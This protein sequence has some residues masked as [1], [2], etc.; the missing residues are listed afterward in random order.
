MDLFLCDLVKEVI[1]F[2][3]DIP[4]FGAGSTPE[5]AGGKF[6]TRVVVGT[7]VPFPIDEAVFVDGNRAGHSSPPMNR[8]GM[9]GCHGCRANVKMRC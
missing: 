1:E 4:G 2:G 8:G 7:D 6:P 9:K 5:F 3:I